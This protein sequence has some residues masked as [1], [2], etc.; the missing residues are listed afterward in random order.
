M[1]SISE[2]EEK[3]LQIIREKGEVLQCDLWK[4]LNVNSREGSRLAL[5]LEKK[6]YVKRSLT[7]YN[8]RKTYSLSIMVKQFNVHLDEVKGCP[9]LSCQHVNGC[10]INQPMDPRKCVF[11]TNWLEQEAMN[12]K[13]P[14][15]L[16]R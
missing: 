7:T 6:G 5:R 13:Y 11:L 4:T 2:L 3:A 8:N 9:C 14:D 10:G 16:M 12:M 15:E 1:T